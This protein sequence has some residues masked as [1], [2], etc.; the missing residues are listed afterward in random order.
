MTRDEDEVAHLAARVDLLATTL[1]TAVVT[2]NTAVSSF[3]DHVVKCAAANERTGSRLWQVAVVVI[4]GLVSV[5]VWFSTQGVPS[6][7]G[8]ADA[9][10]AQTTEIIRA[11]EAHK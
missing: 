11:I 10:R 1:A 2:L 6:S 5:T 4:G 7:Q 9:R 8:V 3:N